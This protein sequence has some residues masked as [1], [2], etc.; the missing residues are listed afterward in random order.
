MVEKL[1][2]EPFSKKNKI[3]YINTQLAITYSKSTIEA[4]EK[5][6]KYVQWKHQDDAN[7]V[8]LVFLLLILNISHTFF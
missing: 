7:G 5:S 8:T 1:F 2:P 3:Y 6:M 4:L